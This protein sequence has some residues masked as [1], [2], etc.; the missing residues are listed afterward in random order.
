MKENDRKI[1][2]LLKGNFDEPTPSPDFTKN[3]MEKINAQVSL[4]EQP[5]SEYVPV[6][7]KLGWMLIGVL[8]IGAVGLGLTGGKGAKF[9]V[10]NHG[11]DWQFDS[12]IIHSQLALFAVLSILALL[13]VDRL[14]S[15][16]RLG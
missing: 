11:P 10:S 12:S 5:A 4:R 14:I 6:I 15:R 7:S 3:I 2:E 8:F 16:F 1:K 9:S 13:I